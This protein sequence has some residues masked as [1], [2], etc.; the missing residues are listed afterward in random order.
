[1]V[2]PKMCDVIFLFSFFKNLFKAT[3]FRNQILEAK[4]HTIVTL[5]SW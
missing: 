2:K 5:N 4:L 3:K 1:M